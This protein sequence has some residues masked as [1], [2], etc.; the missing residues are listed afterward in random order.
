MERIVEELGIPK[1]YLRTTKR[2]DIVVACVHRSWLKSLV[3]YSKLEE[4]TEKLIKQDI[5]SSNQEPNPCWEYIFVRVFKKWDVKVLPLPRIRKVDNTNSP[6]FLVQ[7]L[8]YISQFNYKNLVKNALKNYSTDDRATKEKPITLV[9]YNDALKDSILRIYGCPIVNICDTTLN[10]KT[11]TDFEVHQNI[12]PS[13]CCIETLNT[14]F[15]LQV[16]YIN[17]SLNDCLNFSPAILEKCYTKPLFI[18]YQ[19]LQAFRALHDR[20]LTIGDISLNDIYLTEDLWMYIMPDILS[21]LHVQNIVNEEE[22]NYDCSKIGHRLDNQLKCEYCGVCTYDRVQVNNENLEQICQLWIKGD[23]SNFTYITHLNNLSGR[24]IGDP[25]C[26]HV[27]PWVTDFASRCGKNWRDLKKSKYRLNKGDRQLDLTYEGSQTQISHH[28]SDVLSAIT[29]FVY[30]ARR[31]PKTILCRNVRTIWV[32]AEYPSSIQRM[33]EWTPDECIPEFFTDPNVFR[34]IHDDLDDLEVPPWCSGPE[35]FIERHRSALESQHVSERLHHWIDLTFG[36]KLSGNAAVKAKNVCLHLADD[37]T[38][39]TKSGIVQLFNHPHPC[40]YS[41]SQMVSVIP[42]R[43]VIHKASRQRNRDRSYSFGLES[44]RTED[45]GTADDSSS[46]NNTR[47]SLGF[48]RFLSQSRTSLHEEIDF[49]SSRSPSRSASVGPKSTTFTSHISSRPKNQSSTLKSDIIKLPKEFKPDLPL[50]LLEK[51]HT[52]FSKTFYSDQSRSMIFPH[53]DKESEKLSKQET[54]QNSFTNFIFSE[55]FELNNAN[56]SLDRSNKLSVSRN[57]FYPYIKQRTSFRKSDCYIFCDYSGLIS[58]CRIKE[59][60]V[61]GCLIVEIFFARKLLALSI[62]KGNL[63]FCER[64]KTCVTILRSCGSEFPPCVR[65]IASLLLQPQTTNFSKFSYPIVTKFGLPTPSAHLLLEPSLHINIP[66]SKHFPSLYRLL[67]ILKDFQ[68]ISNEMNILYHFDCDGSSCSEFE[69]LET[70]KM[71]FVQNIAECKVKTCAKLSMSIFEE[72]NTTT[73]VAIVDIMLP[74]I[75]ELLDNPPTSVL[76]AWYLFDPF[77]RMM[78]PQKTSN[79]L[80]V[81]ILKLFEN[82]PNE[83]TIPYYGKIAKLY[84]HSFLLRLMIRLGLKCFL[85]NFIAPLVE[86]VGGYRDY[87]KVD[88]ILHSHNEK[89]SR[90][91]SHLKTMDTEQVET[92][93]IDESSFSAGGRMNLSPKKI[94][95]SKDPEIFDFED[96]KPD[97]KPLQSLIQQLELNI[98]SDLP[99]NHSTAEEALDA[100]LAENIDHLKNLEELKINMSE[101]EEKSLMSPINFLPTSQYQSFNNISCEIGNRKNED[102]LCEKKSI[103]TEDT[104]NLDYSD[105]EQFPPYPKKEKKSKMETRISDMSADS[106]IWLSH[107]LGPVLTARYLSRNLL[108]ML[109]LCYMGKDNLLPLPYDN[110]FHNDIVSITCSHVVGDRNAAKVLECLVHIAGLYGEQFI[111]F[112]YIPHMSELIALFKRKITINLE[113]GLISCLALL[114][115]VIPYLS[116]STLMDQLQDNIL[117]NV[118]HPAVRLLGSTKYSFPS[119]YTA[120]SALTNKYIDTLYV[121]SLRIGSDMTRSHLAVP[122][123]QRFFL[124]FDKL[125]KNE[126]L[127]GTDD[128][129]SSVHEVNEDLN[130]VELNTDGT[131]R[132][133]NISTGRIIQISHVHL[134]DSDSISSLSPP[135][136]GPREDDLENIAVQELQSVF[137]PKLAHTVYMPFLKHL[138]VNSLEISLNNHEHIKELCKEYTNEL[139]ATLPKEIPLRQTDLTK[140]TNM[141]HSGSIGSNVAVIGNRI[142]VQSET[143]DTSNSDL[144]NLVSNKIENNNRHLRG[145]WFAYW[146]HEIGRPDKEIM[147]NFKQIKLQ[148]FSGHSNSVKCLYVLDNENSFMS[149]SRDKTVKLWSLRS[150]G[151]GSSISNCQWTYTA[152][153]KSVLSI[154]FIE[155]M[156]LVASC[157][158]VVHIWDP[159]MGVNLG[160]LE[161]AKYAPV[162][163]LKAM[164]APSCLVYAATTDGTLKLIDT[165]IC[166]Y[167]YELKVAVTPPGL[168]RC[169]AISPSG[170]WVAAGQSSGN[171]TVLD[172]R[173]GLII[174]TWRAHENEV[175]QLVAVD[176][177]TLISSSLDQNISA[178]NI[179]DGKFKFHMRGSTEPVHCLNIYNSEL[180]SGS[181]ANRIGVHTSVDADAS[182]SSTKLR[183]DAFKGLLTSMVVLPL[184]RLL[185][186]GADTGTINL[187]C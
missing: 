170:M 2:E 107:R 141:V 9:N 147:F 95:S 50:D 166:S 165:R 23:I 109:T 1:K 156:R 99:F 11:S 86:A 148:T 41:P 37:H 8:E 186:L 64:L 146:G 160:V 21:N 103:D 30:M 28:V 46:T 7:L 53:E 96:E 84:H 91:T 164:P 6:L 35:D 5:W 39:L 79:A 59:L 13:V 34:S 159:F 133:W 184:N 10:K 173:T 116:D 168:I 129:K 120:R 127:S 157:D 92:S 117:K 136:D 100:T 19:L 144:L 51:K 143:D 119:G 3:K 52:F 154:S 12:L 125:Y 128:R 93:T 68:N 130:F 80:L 56:I 124:I 135:T 121:L 74:H 43:A 75:K 94:N 29:Y 101:D 108:K 153:K 42:I 73:D 181:T 22:N 113:G 54:V 32:P 17:F 161:S 176:N 47:S 88:F 98:S 89:I 66:F 62:N 82:E 27:F 90:K 104:S 78:G 57:T 155:S 76:T 172:T 97:G 112:Q 158:S 44:S 71:L 177:N 87:K 105:T 55:S 72:L 163:T 15:L 140:T 106:L 123:L 145:N 77:S 81:S 185:L 16:P 171:I 48:T 85:D 14:I 178:W 175:L 174:S 110:D 151:D 152:H 63:T 36:Y 162:N 33:Q 40:R 102:N 126:D 142:E 69:S 149:G 122:A 60:Q 169:L 131:S 83:N 179:S 118:I 139:K 38:Y 4:F 70:T 150:Q 134:K 132:E 180:I 20:S 25:N 67:S 115:H 138:G 26:H 18:V 49:K 58:K 114:K 137:T 167:I 31:T 187:L 182:F 65:Y 24:K 61:L 183:S 111:L 45:D